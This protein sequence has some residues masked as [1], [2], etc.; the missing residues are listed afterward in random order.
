MKRETF[1]SLNIAAA[2]SAYS[3]SEIRNMCIETLTYTDFET[4][5]AIVS[6]LFV[7]NAD[8]VE[9]GQ[10][11]FEVWSACERDSFCSSPWD[12]LVTSAEEYALVVLS[13][14]LETG[15]FEIDVN[16]TT[17]QKIAKFMIAARD[18]GITKEMF[19][20]HLSFL[21]RGNEEVERMI[22]NLI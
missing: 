20:K 19:R 4:I 18:A 5:K 7:L 13:N 12:T 11:A 1:L 8:V 3:I 15:E 2:A 22:E 10:E 17:Y 16:E 6:H 9:S 14:V 21:S